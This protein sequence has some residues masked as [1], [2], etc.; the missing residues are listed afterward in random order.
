[1]TEPTTQPATH[2]LTPETIL[3][4]AEEV[5]RRYG[6]AKASVV[7]VPRALDVSHGSVYRHFA[8]KAA[9]R[10]AVTER[11]AAPRGPLPGRG[12]V[13]QLLHPRASRRCPAPR[14]RATRGRLRVISNAS[15]SSTRG[16]SPLS[17]R[18]STSTLSS[19]NRLRFASVRP[20]HGTR[21][22]CR[23]MI[24]RQRLAP[25]Q[26]RVAIHC[27]VAPDGG[28]DGRVGRTDSA[29]AALNL[30]GSSTNGSWPECSNQMSFF[31]GAVSASK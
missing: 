15:A 23:W 14:P 18:A 30:S 31:E 20:Q 6:P 11:R 7:D 5:L 9:L 13:E 12:R 24:T 21:R 10:D 16:G 19:G 27:Q 4:A 22:P 3:D 26:S 1:V 25:S 8:S 2:P 29:I 28:S 17:T